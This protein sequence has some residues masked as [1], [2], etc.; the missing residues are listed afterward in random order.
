MV[1][2]TCVDANTA[3]TASIVRGAAAVPWLEGLRLPARLVG[4]DDTVVR[5]AGWPAAARATRG[6]N[7]QRHPSLCSGGSDAGRP[8]M[9]S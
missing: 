5:V 7:S 6:T 4:N 8:S 1:A 9:R 3:S 2:A